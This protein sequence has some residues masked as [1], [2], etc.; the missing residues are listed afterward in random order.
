[1][2]KGYI[3]EVFVSI[4]GEGLFIG[5]P[6]LFIRFGGCAA[7][8]EHCD[9]PRARTQLSQFTVHG[10]RAEVIPNPVKVADLANVIQPLLRPVP[11]IAITGGEPLEQPGFL[12]L[13]LTQLSSA[14]KKVLLESRAY[15]YRELADVLPRVDVVAASIK[16]PSFSGNPCPVEETKAFLRVASQK[17]CYVKVVVGKDTPEAEVA[18]AARIV[19]SV[20][21]NLAF[22]IQPR[23]EE[24]AELNASGA[25]L[26]AMAVKINSILPD[27]R[28]IPQTHRILG[29]R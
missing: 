10:T 19:A 21:P 25:R 14:G 24:L 22:V 6:M 9:T 29:L 18:E 5:I 2:L 17:S 20:D 23:S 15:H 12:S 8:C 28:L 7:A 27:V 11:F 16:M 1:M 3:D 4:Q 13:L 26:A